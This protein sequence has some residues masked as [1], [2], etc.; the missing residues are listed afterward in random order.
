MGWARAPN[1]HEC[2]SPETSALRLRRQSA[3]ER[4]DLWLKV[5]RFTLANFTAI[6][7]LQVFLQVERSSLMETRLRWAGSVTPQVTQKPRRNH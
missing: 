6:Y 1:F 3:P 2:E 7:F 4:T 5:L